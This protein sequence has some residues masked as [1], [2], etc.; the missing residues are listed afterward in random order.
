MKNKIIILLLLIVS[1]TL[2]YSSNDAGFKIGDGRAF[3]SLQFTQSES[4]ENRN[5]KFLSVPSSTF[6]KTITW[7][8]SNIIILE[9]NGF[10][11]EIYVNPK[12]QNFYSLENVSRKVNYTDENDFFL[13]MIEMINLQYHIETTIPSEEISIPVF[14]LSSKEYIDSI[15][16]MSEFYMGSF[17]GYMYNYQKKVYYLV[18]SDISRLGTYLI[19]NGKRNFEIEYTIID[20]ENIDE[21]FNYIR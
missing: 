20:S 11:I 4:F 17:P 9:E 3:F 18:I 8:Y 2:L 10:Q 12:E 19:N 21:I 1:T 5:S 16:D 15:Y 6:Y 7:F 14:I 13:K